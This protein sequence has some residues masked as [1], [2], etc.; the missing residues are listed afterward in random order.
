L[1]EGV[2]TALSCTQLYGIPCWATLGAKRLHR[3][4]IPGGVHLL[5]LFADNDDVG[6]QA[7]ALATEKYTGQGYSVRKHTPIGDGI[8]D[9][10]D[11][12]LRAQEA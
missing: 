6:Q 11:L 3:I 12:L 1:A 2:E 4:A 7:L 10:N 5:H 9:F 8:K